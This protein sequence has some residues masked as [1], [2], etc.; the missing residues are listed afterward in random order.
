MKRVL[1]LALLLSLVSHALA[2]FAFDLSP[3]SQTGVQGSTV[4]YGGTLRNL[5]SET[6]YL[7]GTSFDL[8]GNGLA[9]DDGAFFTG[10][11][12]FLGG[13]EAWSGDLFSVSI[14]DNVTTGL[15]S[16]RFD[17]LGGAFEES[18]DLLGSSEFGL[19]VRDLTG[20]G[21]TI[22]DFDGVSGEINDFYRAQGVTFTIGNAQGGAS[23]IDT[24]ISASSG[25]YGTA[26]SGA[27]VLVPA[28]GS[29]LD[30]Y[31]N[32]YTTTDRG[33]VDFVA[34]TNDRQGNPGIILQAFSASGVLLGQTSEL[35]ANVRG[36]VST[37]GIA[38]ARIIGMSVT[39]GGLGVDDF[40]FS[41]PVP[42]PA[43]F[44]ALG[45]GALA[46]LR[47]QKRNR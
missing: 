1:S 14:A 16:G 41:Q 2:Q 27:N 25:N 24:G 42:E 39:Q 11:P 30:V 28:T 10:S 45:V 43:A 12:R 7:N 15:Y 3:S 33:T 19:D 34:V 31:M 37:T 29:N 22:V 46:L 38:Y 40:E 5:G 20:N 32:F 36:Y 21:N 35:G 44:A 18:T 4:T 9:L 8:A 26:V 47:R 13:G 23:T 6:L 17:V